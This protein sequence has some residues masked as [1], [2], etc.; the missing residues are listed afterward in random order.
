LFLLDEDHGTMATSRNPRQMFGKEVA[1]EDYTLEIP[2]LQERPSTCIEAIAAAPL[3][4][5]M[6]WASLKATTREP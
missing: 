4:P 5:K 6:T 2:P 1:E 3:R